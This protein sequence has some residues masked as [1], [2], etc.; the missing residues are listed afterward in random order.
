[1]SKPRYDEGHWPIVLVTMPKEELDDAELSQHLDRMSSF[2]KR[3]VPFVHIVDLRMT[4]S[5]SAE[6]RRLIAERSDRD[7]E[8]Y[9]GVLV[10]LA[11]VLATPLQRGIFKAINWLSQAS[12]PS[13]AFSD[14]ETATAWARRLLAAPARS[15]AM[16][17]AADVAK[18][19]G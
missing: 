5:L 16:P 11:V 10:G 2:S 15:A 17:V 14:L 1:M 3:G 13:E 18:R 19:V 8:A 12:R 9:P 4:A 6:A 7:E